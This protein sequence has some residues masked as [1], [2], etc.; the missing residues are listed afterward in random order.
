VCFFFKQSKDATEVKNRFNLKNEKLSNLKSDY[1][2]GFEYPKTAV[3]TDNN[4]NE[5][6]F[7]NWGLIPFWAKDDS[8]KRYTLNAKIETLSEKPSFKK[9]VNNRCLIIADGFFEWQWLDA[10]GKT[11]QK[12]LITLPQNELFAFA[13][14]WSQWTDSVTG[15]LIYSYSILTTEANELM[16]NIHNSKKRMPVILTKNNEI[17]WLDKKPISEFYNVDIQLFAVKI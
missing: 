13:G 6:Q 3:I 2:N 14:I 15:E 5:L 4:K 16:S 7:F 11:K 10:K 12:Y 1:Y 17:D 9:S 8:I